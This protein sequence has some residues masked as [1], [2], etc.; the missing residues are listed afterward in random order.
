MQDKET[1]SLWS[2]ILGEAKA[3]PMKGKTL[4]QI[5]S[6]ITDWNTWR[7]EH[8]DGTVLMLERT[9][10]DYSRDFYANPQR[11][12][13]GIVVDG[14]AKAW[15]LDSLQQQPVRNDQVAQHPVVAVYDSKSGTARLFDRKVEGKVLTFAVKDGKMLDRETASSWDQATGRAVA[16]PFAGKYLMAMPAIMSFRKAWE[17]FHPQS[18][19]AK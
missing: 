12:V 15:R 11:F 19:Y 3:G 8:P 16:G 1:G 13:L 14:K 10:T 4:R 18:E 17:V 6:V 2:H 7:R 5:P 9:S